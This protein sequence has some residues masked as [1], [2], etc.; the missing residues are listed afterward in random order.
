MT[1]DG[2]IFITSVVATAA[3][4]AA[5]YILLPAQRWRRRAAAQAMLGYGALISLS[6]ATLAFVFHIHGI[7]PFQLHIHDVNCVLSDI[8]AYSVA[9]AA[10]AAG[11][12]APASAFATA[13][14][15][16]RGLL[17]GLERKEVP[18]QSRRVRELTGLRR[19][20]LMVVDDPA[21]VD[22]FCFALLRWSRPWLTPR[23]ADYIVVARQLVER[24]PADELCA[25]IM[26]EAAHLRA[27]DGRYT[28]FLRTL[29]RMVFF[30]PVFKL[31]VRRIE[32]KHEFEADRW[33]ASA[34]GRPLALARALL[35]IHEIALEKRPGS[36]PHFAGTAAA[37]EER[38]R[39]LVDLQRDLIQAMSATGRTGERET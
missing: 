34:T 28:P 39:R 24:L 30:D 35:D 25:V 16:L 6:F 9:F 21:V 33:A 27:L 22:A 14:L 38:I 18:E 3:V 1:S 10:I 5:L 2:L 32:E 23:G 20:Y 17:R 36:A 13:Q 15:S 4:G 7:A 11:L 31:F 29:R 19:T 26:H 12:A 37:L 8:C